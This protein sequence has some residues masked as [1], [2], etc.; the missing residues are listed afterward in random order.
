MKDSG[1]E[2]I[3]EIPKDW[4]I[5][6]IG[7]HY[8][9]RNE[10]VS[11]KDYEPLSVTKG[12]VVPQ[13]ETAA[14]SSDH[15]NRKLVLK[16]DFVIN[17]RSD[18]KMSAG[19]AYSN[20]SVSV[21]NTV[22]YSNTMSKEY[23]KYLLKNY[24][25]AEEFFRWG[26]GIVADLWSTKWNKM[27][28]IS[29]PVPNRTEQEK[30]AEKLD[31]LSDNID[32]IIHETK[33]SIEELKK[34]KQSIITEAVTKG[35][36]RNVEMKD[37][38]IEWIGQIPSHWEISKIKFVTEV[39][40]EKKDFIKGDVYIGL[41]NVISYSG[42]LNGY[43]KLPKESKENSFKQGDVLYSKLRPYLAKAFIAETHGSC[44]GEFI[45]FRH[46][47]GEKKYLLYW[48]ISQ[49]FTDFINATS[50]GAKMPRSS[51]EYIKETSI[52]QPPREEERLIINYLEQVTSQI[53]KLMFG[54]EEIIK[55]LNNYKKSLIYEYVTGKKEV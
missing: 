43:S 40:E 28:N 21:I 45:V 20:G 16:D 32:N 48:L 17:S 35:L 52:P 29:I 2:W 46:Y 15:N 5:S 6:K 7:S 50:Y 33:N 31:I 1:V 19:L 8:I 14:K 47:K 39:D 41:E 51:W 11:D 24:S 54:K 23:T 3:G 37:S 27:K 36:D 44:S 10:K 22:I 34:Y 25:F 42:K 18:R 9:E 4:A 55:E 26:S 38:G 30:I 53:D 13:L 49:L 12:G